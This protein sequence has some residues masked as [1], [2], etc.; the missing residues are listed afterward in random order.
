M[1]LE[2]G[3]LL[4]YHL[5]PYCTILHKGMLYKVCY[6]CSWQG[7]LLSMTVIFYP[8]VVAYYVLELWNLDSRNE[9][10]R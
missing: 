5:Y 9:V 6:Y 10:S 2:N 4:Q 1:Q 8:Q 3:L 7:S